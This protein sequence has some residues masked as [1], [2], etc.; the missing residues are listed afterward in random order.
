VQAV[1]DAGR[2]VDILHSTIGYNNLQG[3]EGPNTGDAEKA[4]VERLAPMVREL[5]PHAT[6]YLIQT[7][8][9]FGDSTG[10]TQDY[11]W[12]EKIIPYHHLR[13]GGELEQFHLMQLRRAD[14]TLYGKFGDE[15]YD[16]LL[17]LPRED[18]RLQEEI[19]QA[20]YKGNDDDVRVSEFYQRAT[21]QRMDVLGSYRLADKTF[22]TRLQSVYDGF[23]RPCQV[24][25]C[26]ANHYISVSNL[27]HSYPWLRAE[28]TVDGK[29]KRPIIKLRT[30]RREPLHGYTVTNH[31][32]QQAQDMIN[33]QGVFLPF[34]SV[35]GG[36]GSR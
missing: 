30:K 16:W 8:T 33:A 4:H 14:A 17:P 9:S 18:E 20:R 23:A 1:R 32:A 10:G 3:P 31:T 7:K 35:Q 19:W 11:K 34:A 6:P 21:K 29:E 27:H 15:M 26:D 12:A 25:L 22:M 36:S 2:Q 24:E 13:A 5:H 28:A